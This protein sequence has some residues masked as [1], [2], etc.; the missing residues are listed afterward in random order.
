MTIARGVI[1]ALA[2][3]GAWVLL[4]GLL[5]GLWALACHL[6]RPGDHDE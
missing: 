2:L 5:F 1:S 4:S 3:I 6:A